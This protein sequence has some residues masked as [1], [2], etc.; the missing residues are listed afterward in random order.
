MLPFQATGQLV[1]LEEA[2]YQYF[3]ETED[4][5]CREPPGFTEI[6]DIS[7]MGPPS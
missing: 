2:E 4:V 7:S 5:R 6:E 3:T 1:K